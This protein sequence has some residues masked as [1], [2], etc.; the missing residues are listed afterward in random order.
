MHSPKKQNCMT[1][2]IPDPTVNKLLI[3]GRET[4]LNM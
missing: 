2:A 1:Y 4:V 3:M